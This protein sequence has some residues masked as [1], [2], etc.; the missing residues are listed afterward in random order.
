MSTLAG[1]E[2]WMAVDRVSDAD[3]DGNGHDNPDKRAGKPTGG[4]I[5][6][7]PAETRSRGEYHEALRATIERTEQSSDRVTESSIGTERVGWNAINPADRPPLDKAT[8]P[9]ERALHIL[10]GDPTGGG[11]RSGTGRRG[12]TEFPADW[13]DAKILDAIQDVARAPDRPPTYQSWNGRWLTRGTR[14]E[15]EIVAIMAHDG[16]IW[17]G[18]PRPGGPGV[19]KNPEEA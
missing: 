5:L 2:K 14:Y 18:W 13:D 7:F 4:G 1:S 9:P 16:R 15:V 19:V 17:S 11:H 6:Q 12:K 10:D 3:S 8:I